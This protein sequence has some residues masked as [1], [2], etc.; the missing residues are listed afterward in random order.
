[1][2]INFPLAQSGF[3]PPLFTQ[4]EKWKEG[5]KWG[6]VDLKNAFQV[7][8][9]T[10]NFLGYEV[11]EDS[12]KNSDIIFHWCGKNSTYNSK[13]KV[14]IIEHGWLPRWS[15]QISPLGTNSENHI[16]K[17][18]EPTYNWNE[19]KKLINYIYNL[20]KIYKLQIKKILKMANPFILIPFQLAT[21]INLQQSNTIFS[22]YYGKSNLE[23]A[24]AIV[25]Y[26]YDF[27]LPYKIIFKQHPTDKIDFSNL[28]IKKSDR[29]IKANEKIAT[30]ELFATR[31]CKCVIGINSNALHEALIWNIPT[32]A[33]GNLMWGGNRILEN[34]LELTENEIGKLPLQNQKILAYLFHLIKN[35]WFLSD[36]QNPLM[37]KKLIETNGMCEPYKIRK[38]SRLL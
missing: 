23:F 31:N 6:M 2:K 20:Q 35:Q 27:E 36:F 28:K 1:M 22:K 14:I 38:Q 19:G 32:I 30:H 11:N 16:T 9:R 4:T 13:A 37:V 5:S 34:R 18:F 25:D 15:Y 12:V 3:E 17:K 21:D 24:Q 33:L 8:N 7:L 10:L 26:I 29:L